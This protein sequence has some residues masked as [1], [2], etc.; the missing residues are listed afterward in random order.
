MK[1]SIY[2]MKET[3]FIYP[4]ETANWHFIPITKNVG[5]EIK[6]KYGQNHRGFGSLPVLVTIGKTTWTTSIFPN[7]SSGSYILPIKAK[8]RSLEAIEA[9]EKVD[10]LIELLV[11]SK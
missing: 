4:G 7:K 10:F 9:G 2:K 8:V 6:E 3:M 11:L 1:K 5:Q